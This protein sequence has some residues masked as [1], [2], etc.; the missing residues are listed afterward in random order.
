ML[1]FHEPHSL[2]AELALG[3]I[4]LLVILYR[5]C[6]GTN[7]WLTTHGVILI[8][9][10]AIGG[11]VY[12]ELE[13][14]PLLESSYFLTVTVTTVGYGDMVPATDEGK[15]FTVGYALLGLVF[16]FAALSPLL[17]AL[18]WV[19]DLILKPCTPLEPHETD[20]DGVLDLDDLRSR[21]NWG[22]KYFSA[23]M[24][25]ILIFLLGLGI[26]FFVMDLNPID[27]IY[28]SMITMTTIGYGDISGATS[29]Q[30]I[31]LCLYLPTA[32]AALSDALTQLSTIGTAKDL[33]FSDFA[34]KV[35]K[36]LLGEATGP[37]PNP[38]ETLTEA[39][40]LISIL[41]DKGIVDEMTIQAIRL[42]FAHIT[43]HD[44]SDSLNK[45]LDAKLVF[46]E[47]KSQRRIRQ[48]GGKGNPPA[49]TQ[50]GFEIDYVDLKGAK[51]GG[52]AQWREKCW[53]PRV[54]DGK[55]RE[56][57]NVRLGQKMTATDKRKKPGSKPSPGGG[58]QRLE[59]GGGTPS[60]RGRK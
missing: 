47:L 57:S 15:L 27:G 45:V 1:S 24:G 3:A 10:Y 41:K 5:V 34:L 28:W 52:F 4:A 14:W 56:Y 39:E 53:I 22:F 8:T 29:I 18:I 36:L 51:D 37:T 49:K 38:E 16:V 20:E 50:D 31:V 6:G 19:K 60:S 30:R 2:Y 32:V 25:P 58:Y 40:F 23:L 26:G 48:S 7:E 42:Q 55:P 44:K 59:E 46:E 17:D 13:G 21:G 11:V 54:F 12:D 33:V 43:R 9:Y 35:D